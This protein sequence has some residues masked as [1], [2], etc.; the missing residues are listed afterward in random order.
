ALPREL[1]AHQN[2][3]LTQEFVSRY[4]VALGLVADWVYRDEEGNPHVQLLHT[5]RLAG[6]HGFGRKSRLVLGENGE[7]LRVGKKLIYRDIIGDRN[8]FRKLR[9]AWGSLV[10][11]HLELAGQSVRIDMRS[12]KD[13]GV[14]RRPEVRLGSASIAIARRRARGSQ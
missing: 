8:D 3:A 10:N 5:L 9:L 12:L 6:E 14:D 11:R 13:Q 1:T 2:I 7:P 4:I